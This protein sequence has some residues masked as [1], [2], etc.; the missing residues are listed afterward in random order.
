VSI[1]Q[2]QDPARPSPRDS[3]ANEAVAVIRERSGVQPQV[4]LVLG[5]GLGDA[6]AAEV[7]VE[8]ELAYESLGFP[9][10]TVPGH[11]GRLVMGDLYGVP[12]AVFRGRIHY[13]EGHGIEATTLISQV[14]SA[15]GART[16]VLTNAA[17]GLDRSMRVGQL[18]VIEDHINMLG[19]NPLTGWSYPSGQPA[20]VDLSSVY[21]PGLRS[22]ARQGA[23]DAGI[24]VAHGVYVALPGPSYET[25]A[26]T[27]FLRGA[28]ADAVGMSTVPEAVAAAALGMR[29]LGI[30]LISNLAGTEGSHQDVLDAGSRAGEDLRA[31]L[32]FVV[33]RLGSAE[34]RDESRHEP[35]SVPTGS[36]PA[37]VPERDL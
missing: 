23:A 11:V 25:R 17:G 20:F 8:Q 4:A 16:V 2:P 35:T 32:A 30:T 6:V 22:L 26:E 29:V 24:D 19:V 27:A 9:L 28:G 7:Q 33:P 3:T 12:A 10:P 5:S 14:A 31:I 15:L 21:D 18:M 1:G 34:A 36:E 37:P 13:Y